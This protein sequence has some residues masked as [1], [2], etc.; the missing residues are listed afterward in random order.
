[1]QQLALAEVKNGFLFQH[2]S[3]FLCVLPFRTIL[4]SDAGNVT[5]PAQ[6]FPL[7]HYNDENV[8][9]VYS[10]M[11]KSFYTC[12]NSI[13]SGHLSQTFMFSVARASLFTSGLGFFFFCT[14]FKSAF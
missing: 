9:E 7:V 3:L 6:C 4:R 5:Q 1:M 11:F 8:N 14:F 2:T 10:V 13:I 12:T